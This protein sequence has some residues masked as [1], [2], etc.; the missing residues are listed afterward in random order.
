MI[1]LFIK[2]GMQTNQ[3]LL[4]AVNPLE[5]DCNMY[6]F[7]SLSVISEIV[8]FKA[9]YSSTISLR[10]GARCGLHHCAADQVFF[11]LRCC[12]TLF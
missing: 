3:Q 4:H 7:L 8:V 1:D 10:G 6:Q 11:C 9:L 12:G 5:G 2:L